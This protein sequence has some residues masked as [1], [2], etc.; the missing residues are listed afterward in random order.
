MS[1]SMKKVSSSTASAFGEYLREQEELLS[2]SVEGIAS[3]YGADTPGLEIAFHRVT[4]GAAEYLGV[5][6]GLTK[7]QFSDLHHGRWDGVQLCRP[8]YQPVWALTPEG[9]IQRDERGKKVPSYDADGKMVTR[10]HRTSWI[11]ITCAADKSVMELCIAAPAATRADVIAAWDAAV[12][13]GL[14]GLE[15]RAYLVRKTIS[16]QKVEGT[17]QQGSATERVRGA[18]ILVVPATQLAARHTQSTIDRGAPPDPHLHTHCAVSTLAF[19]PDETH[20]TGMRPLTIDSDGIKT[21]A[22]QHNAIVMGGFARRLE[23]IGIRLDYDAFDGARNAKVGWKIRGVSEQA[24]KFHSSNTARMEAIEKQFEYDYDRPPTREE[25]E[26]L[27]NKSRITKKKDGLDKEADSRGAWEPWRDD[28]AAHGI[29]VPDMDR[30]TPIVRDPLHVRRLEFRRRLMS[31][32]NGLCRGDSVFTGDSI[33]T[34]MQLCAI[35]LGFSQDDLKEM[36]VGLRRDLILARDATED[37]YRYFTTQAQLDIEARMERGRERIASRSVP[38]PSLPTIDRTIRSQKFKIDPQQQEAVKAICYQSLTHVTGVAGSGKSSS[39]TTARQALMAEGKI[40]QTVVVSTAAATAQDSAMKM[41]ADKY[42]A[43]E[44]IELQVKNGSL[45]FTDKTLVIV[46]EAAMMDTDR[47]DRL[48]HAAGGKG[49][50]VFVGDSAQLVPIGAAGWYSESVEAHGAVVLDKTHRFQDHR[51]VRDYALLRNATEADTRTAVENLAMRWRI[52]ESEDRSERMVNVFNDYKAFRDGDKK[53]T[54]D[55]V[56]IL[57]E[58]SNADVDRANKFIQADRRARGE[59]K[60]EGI[61]LHDDEQ[62]RDWKLH[63]NERIIFQ[64]AYRPNRKEESIRNGTTGTILRLEQRRSRALVE[65]DNGRKV[66]VKLSEHEH[67]QPMAPSYARHALKFQGGEKEVGLIMPGTSH[68]ANANSAYSQLT[69]FKREAHVYLDHETHGDVPQ[70]ALVRSWSQRVEKQTA[71][72][73]I[74]DGAALRDKSSH[75]RRAAKEWAEPTHLVPEAGSVAVKEYV[76]KPEAKRTDPDKYR[77]IRRDRGRDRDRETESPLRH[78][79]QQEADRGIDL[80][81]SLE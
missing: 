57:V 15:E 39:I 42:G 73:H 53:L 32:Q 43:V 56:L 70:E 68:T 80:G 75:Q 18:K 12:A 65:L 24:M 5:T 31:Q 30:G 50:W 26:E 49:R 79:R 54:A 6:G 81:L 13:E 16:G 48:F 71:H 62:N 61:S 55:D 44:G 67:Q 69:R 40:D 11:D 8:S 25:L 35:G 74:R 72:A 46:E 36:E 14:K 66:Y 52:H 28:L 47:L 34:S 9:K 60:G 7:A 78:I 41:G 33:M 4:G 21:F 51:D 29:A 76:D 64:R 17:K 59:I 22:E 45:H 77:S 38:A 3:Y 37:R 19:L 2:A 23:D 58:T 20:P 1:V 27:M 63:E 10:L